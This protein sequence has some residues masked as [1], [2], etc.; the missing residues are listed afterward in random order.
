MATF[1]NNKKKDWFS[2]KNES[3]SST[4]FKMELFATI[5]NGRACKQWTIAFVCCCGTR[6]FLQPKLKSDENGCALKWASD[7]ISC[8]VDMFLKTPI[9]F[10]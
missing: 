6:T 1:R 8:F 4:T 10:H 5:G 9:T 3:R 7:T 2:C